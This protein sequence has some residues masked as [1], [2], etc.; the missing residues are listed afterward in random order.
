L[1]FASCDEE[2]FTQVRT[3]DLPEENPRLAV[4]S[5]LIVNNDAFTTFV[6]TSKPILD[7]TE[8]PEIDNAS[9]NLFKDDVL[10]MEFAYDEAQKN[11]IYYGAPVS[12]EEGTYRMEVEATGYDPIVA[13]QVMPKACE[14]LEMSFEEDAF[15]DQ[16]GDEKD[17]IEIKIKDDASE[18]NYYSLSVTAF[19]KDAMGNPL[20]MEAYGYIEDP[21]ME[22]GWDESFVPD[23]SFNGGNYVFRYFMDEY[24]KYQFQVDQGGEIEKFNVVVNS[25]SKE[26]FRHDISRVTYEDS[27]DIPFIEPVLVTTNWDKGF[28]IFSIQNTTSQD[29]EL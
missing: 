6:S 29:L 10:F 15:V 11:Y 25:F 21:L 7:N 2:K 8:Y 14:I 4:T 20:E 19:G 18:D 16:Y 22:Y 27:Q 26:F 5:K 13:T 3:I 28:G 17:I 12:F 1:F 23:L 9:V 24:W